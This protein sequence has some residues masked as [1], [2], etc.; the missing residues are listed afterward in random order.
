MHIVWAQRGDQAFDFSFYPMQ[1]Q[2]QY[3]E[4]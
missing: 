2:F 4:V 1:V 3:P